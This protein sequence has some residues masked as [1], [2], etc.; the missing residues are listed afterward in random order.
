MVRL[1]TADQPLAGAPGGPTVFAPVAVS[2]REAGAVGLAGPRARLTGLA[3]SVIA[4]LA[5]ALEIVLISAERQR[6][7][8]ERLADWS[9]LGWLPQ[10]RPAHGQD[11]RLLLAFDRDQA[12]ARVGELVRRLDDGPLGPGWIT[13]SPSAVAAAARRHTGPHTVVIVDGEPGQRSVRERVARLAADG[14]AAG[15]HLLCLAEAPPA[16]TGAPLSASYEAAGSA[17]SLI[18]E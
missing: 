16:A 4:Q 9:W 5:A 13:A 11:C 3:R 2:L 12:A 1:G 17:S 18:A 10:V 15:V 7:V 8:E 14:P 6:P